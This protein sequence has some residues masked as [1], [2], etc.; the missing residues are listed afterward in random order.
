M[1]VGFETWGPKTNTTVF[2]VRNTASKNKTIK[3][4]NC[5]IN[6]G[7]EKDLLAF[8]QV[9][10]AD[11]RA[12]LLK[13]TLKKKLELGEIIIV[14]SNID[15][16]QFDTV[17][18]SLLQSYGITDGVDSGSYSE[19]TESTSGLLSSSDKTKIDQIINNNHTITVSATEPTSPTT[20][21]IWIDI[22]EG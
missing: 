12:S 11:I 14:R 16:I 15:L 13:G 6:N 17:Q 4:F 10:E 9:S 8:P 3:I 18:K 7:Q 5:K 2:I 22:S 21:D 20:G 1:T 19:A